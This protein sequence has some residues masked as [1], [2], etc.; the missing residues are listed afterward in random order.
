MNKMLKAAFIVLAAV[1][2]VFAGL[3][4]YVGT[5][6][7]NIYRPQLVKILSEKT[8]RVV[9]LNGPIDFSLGLSGLR[10]S[11]EDASIANPEGASRP[12]MASMGKFDL[13]LYLWPLLD[14]RISIR[15]ISIENADILLEASAS[16]QRNWD[17][18]EGA[19]APAAETTSAEAKAPSAS[20]SVDYI[21]IINSQIAFRNA[22]GKV[23]SFNV[24]SLQWQKRATGAALSMTGDINGKPLTLD[25]KTSLADLISKQPF[26]FDIGATYDAVR[27]IAQ[28]KADFARGTAVLSSYEL[29]SGN[30][31]MQGDLTAAWKGALPVL[32]GELKSD[33]IDPADFKVAAKEE[34]TEKE[35]TVEQ[36]QAAPLRKRLFSDEVLPFDSLT[37]F[38]A[39]LKVN[40]GEM[41]VGDAVLRQI[42]AALVLSNGNLSLEPIQAMLGGAVVRAQI[43]ANAA[44]TPARVLMGVIAENVDLK[45]LQNMGSIPAFMLGKGGANIQLAG[46]G[47]TPH[48]IASTLGGVV[49]L[50]AEKGEILRGAAA[51][52]SS[53]LANL[54]NPGGAN[55]VL[56][57]MAARFNVK[58]GVMADNGILVDSMATTVAGNGTINLASEMIAMSLRAKT[59]LVDVGGI[60]P[61]LQ[62]TGDLASPSYAIDAAGT[63]KNVVGA[64]TSGDINVIGSSV[65]D[66]QKDPAGGNACLYTLDHPQKA[67]TSK[68]LVPGVSNQKIKDIGNKVIK[69]LIGQ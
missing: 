44:L 49:V 21:S 35:K 41:P 26:A 14:R 30:S 22:K 27:L 1:A 45:D 43:K 48:E 25:I 42:E 64:L 63:V 16:G 62:I 13:G 60:V 55:N 67:P 69:G 65:P 20:V 18:K 15:E 3:V 12:E 23:N 33:R 54:F 17:F 9:K 11:I 56:N 68:V 57:C 36:P 59:K 61:A 37:A 39:N 47:N 50:R 28:G 46:E 6:D 4:V 10:V 5:M 52:I 51:D 2:A 8:G 34:K 40:I 24:A 7:A 58:N 53:S 38:E 29:S 32:K 66:M 31:K 19:R